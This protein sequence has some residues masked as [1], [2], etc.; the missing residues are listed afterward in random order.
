ML[1]SQTQYHLRYVSRVSTIMLTQNTDISILSVCPSVR[2]SVTFQYCYALTQFLQ[3]NSNGVTPPLLRR[4]R[5]RV[6][7]INFAT[8]DQHLAICWKQYKIGPQLLWNG[9][10]KSHTLCRIVR[11]PMILSDIWK[12]F[13][14]SCWKFTVVTLCAQLTR[15]L[16]AI[17]KCLYN[18]KIVEL[19]IIITT[20]QCQT[21]K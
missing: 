7:Y 20:L 17:A 4:R 6:W 21:S 12:S 5:I 8:F 15:D 13:S 14:E 16:L 19:S 18:I 3:R 11:M 9:N 2:P 10:R 1:H